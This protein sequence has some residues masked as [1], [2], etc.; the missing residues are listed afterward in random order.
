MDIPFKPVL[1]TAIAGAAL[2]GIAIYS[3]QTATQHP[4]SQIGLAL[5][6]G[7]AVG[8][9]IDRVTVGYVVDFVDVYWGGWHFW[10]FNVA[11]A[12]ISVGATLLILD[13][14]WVNPHVSET[15]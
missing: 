8:N 6:M 1:M 3:M 13:M 11:D 2:L 5:V 15:A 14:V 7:G 12:S 4:L 10:A 9:L